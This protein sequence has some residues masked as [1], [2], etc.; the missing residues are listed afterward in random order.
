MDYG[1]L[2]PN[3]ATFLRARRTVPYSNSIEATMGSS[4][5]PRARETQRRITRARARHRCVECARRRVRCDSQQPC[6][7]CRSAHLEC[8]PQDNTHL[9]NGS[10]NS[11]EESPGDH[12]AR[13]EQ[14]IDETIVQH[15]P[16]RRQLSGGKLTASNVVPD[17]SST[18]K[19]ETQ[20]VNPVSWE[21]M[22]VSI[23]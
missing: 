20:Y 13:L 6:G 7:A 17:T 2:L 22:L 4:V 11:I 12:F 21:A 3:R 5:K 19:S 14:I 1:L 15:G 10:A 23:L 16:R 9:K 8:L 18:P